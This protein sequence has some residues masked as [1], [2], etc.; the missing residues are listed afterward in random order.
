M[1]RGILLT[2]VFCLSCLAVSSR[3]LGDQMNRAPIGGQGVYA[4]G[5]GPGR[6]E[7]T[8]TVYDTP[9]HR[10]MQ[11]K[12][13]MCSA[14]PELPADQGLVKVT[15]V[16]EG[17]GSASATFKDRSLGS[18][19]LYTVGGEFVPDGGVAGGPATSP[20]TWSGTFNKRVQVTVKGITIVEG[21]IQDGVEGASNWAAV[22]SS[23]KYAIAE[24]TIDPDNSDAANSVDW[25]AG[26]QIAGKPKQRKLSLAE[27]VVVNVK[28]KGTD[29]NPPSTAELNL[30][31]LWATMTPVV[32]GDK[33]PDGCKLQYPYGAQ[34]PGPETDADG[35][36]GKVCLVT[37]LSPQGVNG[38]VKGGWG[39]H[40]QKWR[41]QL[42]DGQHTLGG[43]D[44][45]WEEDPFGEANVSL[46]PDAND[47]LYAID[48]PTVG[49]WHGA[50]QSCSRNDNFQG[51]VEWHGTKCSSEAGWYYRATWTNGANP[52]VSPNDIKIGSLPRD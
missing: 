3:T 17:D 2:G 35:G 1:T 24:V 11:A 13:R 10:K 8:L 22:R 45:G 28:V 25:S 49:Q 21:A 6:T 51:W 19:C 5:S 23:D 47:R 27:P 4:A 46:V 32:D 20:A 14:A 7:D 26:E 48:G 43:W 15:G 37:A 16:T 29:G 33:M 30:W 38:V 42:T 18:G 41:H 31:V 40:F 52:A 9:G 36:S 39:L 50:T 44:T 12:E 34:K